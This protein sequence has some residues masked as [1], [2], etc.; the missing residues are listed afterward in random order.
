M[1]VLKKKIKIHIADDHKALIEGVLSH[2]KR[3]TDVEVVGQSNNGYQVL[4][5][6]KNNTADILLLDIEM[7]GLSGL[8]VL[9]QL[10]SLNVDVKVVMFSTFNQWL[11]VAKALS[12]NVKG[13]ILKSEIDIP[14]DR[15]FKLVNGGRRYFT[16]EIEELILKEDFDVDYNKIYEED[17]TKREKEVLGYVV[18]EYSDSE[19]EDV[20]EIS[21]STIRTLKQRMRNKFMVKTSVGLVIKAYLYTGNNSK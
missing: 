21:K 9:E 16:K 17:F 6:F 8:D 18:D 14:F 10:D 13:Y 5:W 20:M 15:V 4:D 19:I 3:L 11:F 12:L 2:T 1:T 7:P